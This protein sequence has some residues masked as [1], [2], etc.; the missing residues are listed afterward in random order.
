MYNNDSQEEE[1]LRMIAKL[2]YYLV[3]ALASMVFLSV[4]VLLYCRLK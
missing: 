1:K 4:L 3:L 2:L